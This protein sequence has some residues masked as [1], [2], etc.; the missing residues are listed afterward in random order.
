MQIN[1]NVSPNSSQPQV[2]IL[3]IGAVSIV[4]YWIISAIRSTALI[5]DSGF[6]R[7]LFSLGASDLILRGVVVISIGIASMYVYK[8][9]KEVIQE[10]NLSLTSLANLQYIIDAANCPIVEI[11]G[12]FR[13]K[14]VNKAAAVLTGYKVDDLLMKEVTSALFVPEN[15][16]QAKQML[17]SDVR[18]KEGQKPLKLKAKR[19]GDHYVN[20]QTSFQLA[21]GKVER[22][23]LFLQ[24]IT[25]P[26]LLYNQANLR[27]NSIVN[28]L[29]SH[30]TPF[31][32]L[33]QK[34]I[35]YL[36]DAMK[37][38]FNL[39]EAQVAV[40][41]LIAGL[42]PSDS[43]RD[44]IQHGIEQ[45]HSNKTETKFD[46]ILNKEKNGEKH[47]MVT[48][49]PMNYGEKTLV[50]LTMEDVTDYQELL[51]K[52]NHLDA[53][54]TNTKAQIVEYQGNI[55]Q[56]KEYFQN[57]NNQLRDKYMDEQRTTNALQIQLENANSRIDELEETQ[58]KM[59][60]LQRANSELRDKISGLNNLTQNVLL[61]LIELDSEGI[62]INLNNVAK[63]LM[64]LEVGNLLK[65]SFALQE[66]EYDFEQLLAKL[67]Q[68]EKN[69]HIELEFTHEDGNLT[70][71]FHGIKSGKNRMLLYGYDITE[72][73]NTRRELAI[74]VDSNRLAIEDLLNQ[75]E[76]ERDRTNAILSNVGDG[77]II[78]DMYNRITKMNPVAEDLLG[79]RLSQAHERPIQ[80]VIRN[81]QIL[82]HIKK[83]IRNRLLDHEFNLT[84]T[85]PSLD[86]PTELT[87]KTTVIQD[88]FLQ[89]QGVII[90]LQKAV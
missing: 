80:F 35:F 28:F 54:L 55:E 11:D 66:Q 25:G 1:Q 10:K 72:L 73:R 39:D 62:I 14:H 83:T 7:N 13:I 87:V 16:G 29:Q 21:E 59:D 60:E 76:V 84:V 70:L 63:D 58:S 75:I 20:L 8:I 38:W 71:L 90:K 85:T 6:F 24:D 19:L 50:L 32:L 77:I 42:Q 64:D 37:N 51:A 36:N 88:R 26:T 57:E 69:L 33:D 22:I 74:T 46:L 86:E 44:K 49:G 9:V 81:N 2:R 31:A 61:P 82:E 23:F 4:I 18:H 56:Q 47:L 5:D 48:V 3:L 53:Q 40:E 89:D 43:D 45:A 79:I 78:C 30:S 67:A 12:E 41:E 15:Q 52:L 34:D 68:G 17:G 65:D 27:L